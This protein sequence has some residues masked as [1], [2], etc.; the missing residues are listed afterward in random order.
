[1]DKRI[2]EF[3]GSPAAQH[4]AWL[5][6]QAEAAGADPIKLAPEWVKLLNSKRN[7]LEGGK[8]ED[9]GDNLIA[10]IRGADADI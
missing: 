9:D 1:M 6:I 10:A 5:L 4:A 8:V 3:E 7:M 2:A